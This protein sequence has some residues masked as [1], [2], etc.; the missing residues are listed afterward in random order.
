MLTMLSTETTLAF[1]PFGDIVIVGND[2]KVNEGI[3]STF[4]ILIDFL[5]TNKRDYVFFPDYGA[6]Y[7]RYIGKSITTELVNDIVRRIRT[8]INNLEIPLCDFCEIKKETGDKHE[9][10]HVK[11]VYDP[12]DL[13]TDGGFGIL[14]HIRQCHMPDDDQ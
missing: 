5:K 11:T 13:R 1:D 6:D 14:E 2:L 7:D 4:Q 8:D 3:N 10:R 9:K 12:F